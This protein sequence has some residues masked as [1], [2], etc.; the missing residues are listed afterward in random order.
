MTNKHCSQPPLLVFRGREVDAN[1][2]QQP[3]S[4]YRDNPLIEALPPILTEEEAMA[5]LMHHPRFDQAERFLPNHE[6]LHLITEVLQFFQPLPVHTDLEQRFS[7]LRKQR[8]PGAKPTDC[9]VLGRCQFASRV[10]TN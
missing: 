4:I 10:F 6:R 5:Q 7:R 8:L 9:W 1:Y 2:N 3:L